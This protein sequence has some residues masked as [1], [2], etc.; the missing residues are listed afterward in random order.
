MIAHGAPGRTTAA[1]VAEADVAR[2]LGSRAPFADL[3]PETVAALVATAGDVTVVLDGQG[4]V[5]DVAYGS[6]ELAREW[7]S[8]WIGRPW[9][10]A[11]AEDSRPKIEALLRDAAAGEP[12]RWRHVNHPSGLHGQDIPVQYVAVQLGADRVVASGRDLRALSALQ[13]R[14]VAA[15]Q[16]VERDYARLRNMEMRYR[17]LF[18]ATPEAILIVDAPTLRISEAN[19]AAA[20]LLDETAERLVGRN[21]LEAFDARG[22]EAVQT[23]LAAVRA[24][25]RADEAVA[26]AAGAERGF[27]VAASLFR[28]DGASL[29]L[30]RLAPPEEAGA[31]QARAKAGLGALLEKLPDALVVTDSDGRIA[32]ANHAFLDLAQLA[33]AEQARGEPLERWLGRPGVD[34]GVLTANLRQHGAVRLYATTLRGEFGATLDV[35]VS[36]ASTAEEGGPRFGFVVRNVTR[37]IA[38]EGRKPELPRSVEQLKELVGRVPLKTLVR[39]T[40]DVVEQLCIEAA[41]ELTGDNRA[42]AAEI[43]GLSRQSLYVKLRRY[44]LGDV[45]DDDEG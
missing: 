45:S 3:A 38:P 15:Q 26:G 23:L 44:G 18:Q 12:A 19:P 24:T 8:R 17:L 41:L 11:A 43:L 13:Q 2:F 6:E 27:R 30:V 31:A 21:L 16:S 14:L 34:M 10:E 32:E 28:H 5:R 1:C 4:V 7:G 29:F 40:T 22:A 36:A 9:T 42:S 35:E 39:E 37:R 25:G 20:A 33:T